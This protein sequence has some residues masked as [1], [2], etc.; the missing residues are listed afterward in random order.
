MHFKIDLKQSIGKPSKSVVEVG[1]IVKTGQKIAEIDGMGSNIHSS[2]DGKVVKIDDFSI[3]IDGDVSESYV[4]IDKTLSHI[5]TIEEAGVVGSGGA[6]FPTHIKLA[7]KVKNGTLYINCA[8]C[9]PLLGH[10][11]EYLKNN[12][13][14]LISGI[15]IVLGIIEC[16]KA[17]IA[18][19][20]KHKNLIKDI[21]KKLSNKS[22]IT[23]GELDN[24]YPAGDERVIIRELH[25]VVL[26]PGQLPLTVGAVVLNLETV[27][28][29]YNAVELRKPV[30]TK[31]MTYGGRVKDLYEPKVILDVPIG[32]YVKDIISTHGEILKP[33]G[34][35][36]M[37]GPFTGKNVS[38]EDSI[39]KTSGGIFI[40]NPF[41]EAKEKFGIIE[42]D[43]GASPDRLAYIV[44]SMNGEVVASEKCKRMKE[45]DGR[46]RC[47]KPGECP[48]QA[49]VCLKLKKAG[50]TAIL[51]STCED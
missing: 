11:I 15:K 14:N 29:I 24:I 22:N 35:I 42:C 36:V 21:N 46:Y 44:E 13:D 47:E 4:E 9:E 12:F 49:E 26:E 6:G 25:G 18:I 38:E 7:E 16:E 2:V 3:Y 45:V 23:I 39:N 5:K 40:T 10:N 50:A 30:I 31:D 43:C 8:E 17:V 48:G 51:A 27:K 41:I 37:G 34:E 32:T 19:K 33:Y 28:N 20:K 1:D